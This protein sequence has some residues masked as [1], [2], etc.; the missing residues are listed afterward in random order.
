MACRVG[1]TV[2]DELC[3]DEQ[4]LLK[5]A[6]ETGAYLKERLFRLKERHPTVIKAVKGD[7]LMLGI[8]IDVDIDT[9]SG[10]RGGMLILAANSGMLLPVISGYLAN[11]HHI[12]VAPTLNSQATLRVQ[13][14]INV[15]REQCDFFCEALDETLSHVSIG[16]TYA[17]IKYLLRSNHERQSEIPEATKYKIPPQPEASDGRFGFLIH[18]FTLKSFEYFDTSLSGISPTDMRE[19]ADIFDGELKSTVVSRARITAKDGTT[20]Y[21]EY[22]AVPYLPEQMLNMPPEMILDAV[23]DAVTLLKDRGAKIVGL[24]GYTSIVAKGGTLVSKLGVAVTTGNNYTALSAIQAVN[25]AIEKF[26]SEARGSIHVAVVGAGGSIGSTITR[27][28]ALS[29]NRITLIGNGSNVEKAR[30]RICEVI[31]DLSELLCG[32]EVFCA[33]IQPNSV[34]ERLK[35]LF[36]DLETSDQDTVKRIVEEIVSGTH[37]EL[38]IEWGDGHR[39]PAAKSRCYLCCYQ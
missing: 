33:G 2:I 21:G 10:D 19:L 9:Y 37:N 38:G 16:N 6:R 22:A 28:I 23:K 12:R 35:R 34:A 25:T 14:P 20:I 30:R 5:H 11:V 3:A 39:S 1:N 17:L 26:A 31:I 29:V 7:G 15:T 4:A 27:E 8:E 13:P 36:D 32:D 18:P 24:G